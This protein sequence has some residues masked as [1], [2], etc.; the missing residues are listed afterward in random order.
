MGFLSVET[1]QGPCVC[2]LG[3][4]FKKEDLRIRLTIL[5]LISEISLN[6]KM[7]LGLVLPSSSV[8]IAAFMS[9]LKVFYLQTSFF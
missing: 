2:V 6:W 9:H 5:G 3:G 8:G 4:M 7:P 1:S